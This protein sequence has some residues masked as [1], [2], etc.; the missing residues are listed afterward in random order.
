[1][2][3]DKIDIRCPKCDKLIAKM[4]RMGFCKNIYLYCKSCK[5]EYQITIKENKRAIEPISHKD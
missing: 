5:K 3:N 2:E 1:M 4:D